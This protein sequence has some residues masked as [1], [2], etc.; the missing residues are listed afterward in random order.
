MNKFIIKNFILLET[1]KNSYL[2]KKM[3][4]IIFNSLVTI[5]LYLNVSDIIFLELN[6]NFNANPVGANPVGGANPI[7]NHEPNYNPTKDAL[8]ML[9]SLCVTM[10]ISLLIGYYLGSQ[11]LIHPVPPQ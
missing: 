3:I 5:Y 11:Q 2:Y 10:T 1:V 7:A 6:D 9:G 4:P 8:F